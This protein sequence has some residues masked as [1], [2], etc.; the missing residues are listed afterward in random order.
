MLEFV[1][2]LLHLLAHMDT[3]LLEL[4]V[5]L[6]LVF[7]A[8][9]EEFGTEIVVL[10][11]TKVNVQQDST[12]M[13]LNVFDLSQQPAHLD[14]FFKE[15]TVLQH[16]LFHALQDS[17]LMEPN[18]YNKVNKYAL[19]DIET[20]EFLVLWSQLQSAQIATSEEE[21]IVLLKMYLV[22]QINIIMD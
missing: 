6:N 19:K 8:Q 13:V 12:S 18:V 9:M 1:L 17:Y 21:I 20:M 2:R 3:I 7:L 22:P 14:I 4:L 10:L 5:S 15:P 16:N 11:L